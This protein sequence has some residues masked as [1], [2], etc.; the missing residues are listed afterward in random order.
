MRENPQEIKRKFE[1]HFVFCTVLQVCL[2][3]ICDSFQ[4][5]AKFKFTEEISCHLVEISPELSQIQAKTL[6]VDN[7]EAN[8]ASPYQRGESMS[9]IPVH[10]Y[11]SLEEVPR[12]FS[13]VIAHE[14]FD[15]LPIH[16]FQVR[17]YFIFM[18][19]L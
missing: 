13:C 12:Q 2:K 1:K 10:W 4:V 3:T 5:F 16:K 8:D 18:F 6:V 11:K 9:G 15:A 7:V 17:F 19:K 14:F